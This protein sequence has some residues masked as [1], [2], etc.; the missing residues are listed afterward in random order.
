MNDCDHESCVEVKYLFGSISRRIYS[1]GPEGSAPRMMFNLSP[2]KAC[3][4]HILVYG[5]LL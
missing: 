3:K 1:A 2:N 5:G 4:L